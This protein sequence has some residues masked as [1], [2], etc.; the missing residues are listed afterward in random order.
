MISRKELTAQRDRLIYIIK[1]RSIE[2]TVASRLIA[3]E[4]GVTT[5][6]VDRIV[7]AEAEKIKNEHN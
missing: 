1:F 7:K 3:E 4:L 5:Q 6:A 2:G